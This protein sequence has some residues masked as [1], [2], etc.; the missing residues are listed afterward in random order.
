MEFDAGDSIAEIGTVIAEVNDITGKVAGASQA[1]S[2]A[3]AEIARNI[4]DAFAVVGQ[5]ATDIQALGQTAKDTEYLAASTM[6]ASG[7]LSSQSG[8]LTIPIAGAI[9]YVLVFVMKMLGWI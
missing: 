7:D 5:I 1:Q 9:A 6:T 3:T 8:L 2:Q 4:D